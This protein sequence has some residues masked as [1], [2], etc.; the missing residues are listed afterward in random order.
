MAKQKM[1]FR[2]KQIMLTKG[3]LRRPCGRKGAL[4]ASGQA[5]AESNDLLIYSD[6]HISQGSDSGTDSER[7][8][9]NPCAVHTVFRLHKQRYVTRTS[10]WQQTTACLSEPAE[11]GAER[12]RKK[13]ISYQKLY[14]ELEGFERNGVCLL[15]DGS[16]ASPMQVVRAHM[17]REEGAYM[18]DYE[19]DQNGHIETLSFIN[20]NTSGKK[21]KGKEGQV[22]P[23]DP[24]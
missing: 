21:K 1:V 12:M 11:R 16:H 18:R 22:K 13:R 7:M 10:V 3:G 24:D 4:H 15:I 20:I 9:E 8:K 23:R 2:D 17:V 6:C 19:V 5:A 14:T